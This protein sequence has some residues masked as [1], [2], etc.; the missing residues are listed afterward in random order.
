M[1]RPIIIE[2]AWALCHVTS[3]GGC[4]E[5]IYIDDVDHSNFL[6]LLAQVS[7]DYKIAADFEILFR[8]IEQHKI[9]TV[10]LS[11]VLVKMRLGGTTNKNMANVATQN[12]EIFSISRRYH[13][14]F[15]VIRFVVS[16]A[17]NRT[18]QLYYGYKFRFFGQ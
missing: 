15:S 11:K 10:Y 13:A 8:I 18:A 6:K 12:K 5:D 1:T 14:D 17:L 7:K 2:Y 4:Q 16:K 9:K 3:R